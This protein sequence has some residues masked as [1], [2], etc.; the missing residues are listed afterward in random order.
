MK[1]DT[2]TET[3][4]HRTQQGHGELNDTTDKTTSPTVKD[5]KEDG[6]T[7]QGNS[8][9]AQTRVAVNTS[10]NDTITSL[11]EFRPGGEVHFCTL[12]EVDAKAKQEVQIIRTPAETRPVREKIQTFRGV[13]LKKMTDATNKL[14][15][16]RPYKH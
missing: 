7:E 2:G 10:T 14:N 1:D 8:S 5:R 16:L 3:T 12:K 13:P 11:A 6:E 15:L 9:S 4:M